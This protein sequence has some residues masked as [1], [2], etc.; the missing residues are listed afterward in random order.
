MIKSAQR[1]KT[2]NKIKRYECVKIQDNGKKLCAEAK[3]WKR[4]HKL[5]EN[6][7]K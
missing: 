4:W 7:L 1:K 6:V 5:V 3:N 2:D